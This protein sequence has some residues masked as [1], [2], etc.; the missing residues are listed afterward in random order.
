NTRQN[1]S[2]ARFFVASTCVIA[3]NEAN[4]F[5]RDVTS[6][7]RLPFRIRPG[8]PTSSL[9][10]AANGFVG[11]G[12]ASPGLVSGTSTQIL[13]IAGTS[14]PGLALRNTN[15]TARQYFMYV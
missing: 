7:S 2:S 8:A 14:N 13:E 4:F 6:G 9:D 12:T 15:G 10:I 5:V 1:T 11:V 3:G